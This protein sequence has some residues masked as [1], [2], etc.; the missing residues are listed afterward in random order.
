MRVTKINNYESLLPNNLSVCLP[1]SSAPLSSLPLLLLPIVRIH[2]R[3]VLFIQ[4]HLHAGAQQGSQ[5]AQETIQVCKQLLG[6]QSNHN[7]ERTI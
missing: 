1:F 3:F 6:L 2:F 5:G 4:L 7:D